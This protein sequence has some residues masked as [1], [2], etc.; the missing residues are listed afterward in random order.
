MKK[1]KEFEKNDKVVSDIMKYE[2]M[3]LMHFTKHPG[4]KRRHRK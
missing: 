4:A 1:P 3:E 2:K